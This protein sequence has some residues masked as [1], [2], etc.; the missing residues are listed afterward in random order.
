LR[1]A[2]INARV[3]NGSVALRKTETRKSTSSSVNRTG[4]AGW[5]IET[6]FVVGESPDG[7]VSSKLA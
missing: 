4:S 1:S 6:P 7:Q 3:G 2:S 5:L